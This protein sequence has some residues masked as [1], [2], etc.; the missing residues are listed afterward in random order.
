MG[1]EG[2]TKIAGK[3][4]V[5]VKD[6]VDWGVAG[7]HTSYDQ[8]RL[9]VEARKQKAAKLIENGMSQRTAAKVLGISHTQIY[10]DVAPKVP[11]TG[12][13][14]A[15]EPKSRKRQKKRE[16]KIGQENLRNALLMNSAAAIECAVY[17]GV[18]DTEIIKACRRTAEVWTA[19]ADNL[20]EKLNNG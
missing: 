16:E 5:G 12:T 13:K 10:R 4:L 2:F 9:T 17:E 8:F 14:G 6:L 15:T 20:E 18:V 1:D 19:L 11:K 7:G 3:L